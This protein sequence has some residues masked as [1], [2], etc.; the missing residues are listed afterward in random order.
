MTP[1]IGLRSAFHD[2][3]ISGSNDGVRLAE[4][5]FGLKSSLELTEAGHP[6]LRIPMSSNGFDEFTEIWTVDEPIVTGQIDEI[7]YAHTAEYLFAATVIP[8]Q[9]GYAD[10]ALAAY[11]SIF[12]LTSNLDFPNLFRVWNFIGGIVDP[13]AAGEEIYRDFVVGRSEAFKNYQDGLGKIPAATGIG[14]RSRG[15]AI[16]V[17]AS[18]TLRPQHVENSRQLPAYEYPREYGPK[19][20]NFARATILQDPQRPGSQPLFVSGTASILGHETVHRDDIV[21]QTQTVLENIEHLISA[22]NIAGQGL[23]GGHKLTDL[24]GLKVYVKHEE[25]LDTVREIVS[26]AVGPDA[27]VRYLNVDVCREDLLVE[28]EGLV[29]A[30]QI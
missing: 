7:T 14:T 20:P 18:R 17:L 3:G 28:I 4:I 10:A 9:D 26:E 6:L 5:E 19:S 24:H 2:S 29:P 13:N 15:I 8:E 25:H 1:T 16:A 30:N 12:K 23:S 22:E 11:R 27:E 21:R